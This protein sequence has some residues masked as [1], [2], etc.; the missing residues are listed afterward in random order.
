MQPYRPRLAYV[1]TSVT[2]DIALEEPAAPSV[3]QRLAAFPRLVSSNLLEAE[4]RVAYHR[5]GLQFDAG[6]V[7]NIRWGH[8]T[9]SLGAEMFKALET[10]GY[11]K[12]AY[13]WHIAV[14]LYIAE[15][16][17]G[18]MAFVTLDNRQRRV[19]ENLGFWIP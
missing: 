10:G 3:A 6:I 12:G 4:M 8:P 16:V 5:E 19:A 2:L 14:A 18:Q 11:L 7:G 13:L 15:D 17:A 1:D 9:R